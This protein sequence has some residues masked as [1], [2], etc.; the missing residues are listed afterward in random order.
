MM[1]AGPL[2]RRMYTRLPA[3]AFADDFAHHAAGVAR[4]NH[5]SFGSAPAPVLA[6]EHAIR[7]GWLAQPDAEYFSRALD[8]DLAAAAVA[9]GRAIGAGDGTAALVENATVATA[10]CLHRWRDRGGRALL[11]SCAYGGVKRAALALLGRERVVESPV[12]FPGTTHEGVLEALDETL[13]RQRPRYALLDHIASQP[14][15]V[16]PVAAMVALCRERGVEEVA[17]DGAHALGQVPVDVERISADVYYSNVHKW[18]FAGPTATVLH[19]RDP[20][21]VRHAVPSWNAGDGCLLADAR[22]TGTRDYAAMRAVPRALA[23]LADWRSTDGLDAPTFN[24]AGLRAAAGDLRRAWQVG[25]ACAEDDCFA[26]MGM[27]RLPKGLDMSRDAP[28]VPNTPESLRSRLRADFG[29]EAA[30]GGFLDQDGTLGGFLRLSHAV[31]T[32]DDDVVRLRDAV[33]ALAGGGGGGAGGRAS[34]GPP[35]RRPLPRR[36]A[37]G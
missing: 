30:V 37:F 19:A 15:L 32:T 12:A 29:V 4:L 13:A 22:W 24:A 2:A 6:A 3:K 35:P 33:L 28:G 34:A 14:A 16:L 9:A 31:Y 11:L 1:M 21:A 26:S 5:G 25:P 8:E 27:L 18:A 36:A 20:A 23:Y 17:V 7:M 10:I